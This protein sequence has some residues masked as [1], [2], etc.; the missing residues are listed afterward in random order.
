M[1]DNPLQDAVE[2]FSAPI[3]GVIIALG[4]G[5]ALAQAALDQNSI[6]TQEQLDTDPLLAPYGLQAAWYQFPRVD[7]QLKLSLTVTENR[8]TASPAAVVAAP[9]VPITALSTGL[10][11]VA[12][13]VSAAYQ[14][15][16]NYDAEAASTITLS[17][18][19]V[20]PP[21]STDQGVVQPRM[22]ATDVQAAAFASAAGFAT[23]KN[24]DGTVVPA[25][26]LLFSVNFNA[27]ART[28]YV[29]QYSPVDPGRTVVAVDDTTGLVRIISTKL[30]MI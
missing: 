13:P 4:K 30:G 5:I 7:L 6:Q 2:V 22:T 9:H 25:P 3:E 12:Q 23:V 19:P 26:N 24:A 29:L 1:P 11:L 17:I 20:P 16:F 14:N 8:T 10:R 21:R 15:H 28:W 27:A 18:V